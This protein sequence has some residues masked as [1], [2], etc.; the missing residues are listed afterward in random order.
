MDTASSSA[1]LYLWITFAALSLIGIGAVLVW[2]VRSGQF[3]DMERARW[4][5]LGGGPPEMDGKDG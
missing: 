4:L 1:L 3:S 5:P 2:A